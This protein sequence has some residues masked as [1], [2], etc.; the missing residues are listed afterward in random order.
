MTNPCV[1]RAGVRQVFERQIV[2]DQVNECPYRLAQ[3][4]LP[5]VLPYITRQRLEVPPEMLLQLLRDRNL[6]LPEVAAME[7]DTTAAGGKW[8]FVERRGIVA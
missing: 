4:G 6:I 1:A 2:R 8:G 7:G 5:L 3:E